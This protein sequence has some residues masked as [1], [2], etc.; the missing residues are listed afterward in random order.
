M[1]EWELRERRML[2]EELAEYVRNLASNFNELI[3]L[4]RPGLWVL[5]GELLRYIREVGGNALLARE[6]LKKLG[7]DQYDYDAKTAIHY[8]DRIVSRA[9]ELINMTNQLEHSSDYVRISDDVASLIYRIGM[10]IDAVLY[11]LERVPFQYI[12]SRDLYLH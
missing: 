9:K 8:L 3:Q 11:L 5:K 7:I 12:T 10:D 4:A 6:T 1:I 2:E